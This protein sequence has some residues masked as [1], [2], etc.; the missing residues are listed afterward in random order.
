MPEIMQYRTYLNPLSYFLDIIR[1]IFL[2]DI[3][4]QV[5][6]LFVLG[7]VAITVSSLCF[8]KRLA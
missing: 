7:A 3:W 8:K 2:K 5:T 1:G 6:A 4:P